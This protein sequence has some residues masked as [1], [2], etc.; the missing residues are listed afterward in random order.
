MDEYEVDLMDYLQVMWKGKWIILACFILA[1]AISAA[2][3]C[4]RPNE[5]LGTIHYQLYESLS[6]FGISN[7]DKQEVVNTFLDLEPEY[8]DKG[9]TLNAEAR[10]SRVWVSLMGAVSADAIAGMFQP[11]AASVDE[12]LEEYAKRLIEQESLDTNISIDQ[13]KAQQEAIT[14]QISTVEPYDSE[15]PLLNYL[16]QKASELEARLIQEQVKLETLSSK[17]PET[18]FSLDKLS[19]PIIT[20]VGP[21]RKMSLA[22]AG[23]LSLFVGILLAFFVHYLSS[24]PKREAGK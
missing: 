5:Y 1:V 10:N 14:E 4:T 13:L 18:L 12:R 3:M 8:K 2:I 7:L 15:N 20:L 9:I 17:D 6:S 11:L 22:V 24:A 16:T 19:D 21:N 23:V